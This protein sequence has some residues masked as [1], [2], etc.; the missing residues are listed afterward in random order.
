MV[1]SSNCRMSIDSL[2]VN[3]LSLGDYTGVIRSGTDSA[4]AEERMVLKELGGNR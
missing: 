1:L 2:L 3:Q 4:G